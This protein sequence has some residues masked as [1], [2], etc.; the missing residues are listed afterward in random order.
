MRMSLFSRLRDR[1]P[2]AR[3]FAARRLGPELMA[4]IDAIELDDQGWGYDAFGASKEGMALATALLDPAYQRYFRVQARGREHIPQTGPVVLAVNH[5]GLIPVDA[6]M[7]AIDLIRH[8]PGTR[9]PKVVGDYFIPN[10]PWFNLFF[11]RGGGISGSRGNVH[12]VLERG[13]LLV[14]F[15]EGTPGIGKPYS[16]RYQLKPFRNGFAELAIQHQATIVPVGIVG[17]EESWPQAFR[18]DAL[19]AFGAPFVPVPL[20]PLP[21]PARFTLHYGEPIDVP[22]RYTAEQCLDG[23]VVQSLAAEVQQQVQQLLDDGVAEREGVFK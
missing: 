10:L 15:P 20:V 14:V 16:E 22:G 2:D 13:G 1:L 17:A 19:K 9:A 18:I 12:A 21:L 3:S 7:L 4:H 11:A 5:S 6:V 8:A 23:A